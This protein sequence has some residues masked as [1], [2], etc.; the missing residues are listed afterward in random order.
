[1]NK[2]TFLVTLLL[3]L[4]IFSQDHLLDNVYI[5]N[6]SKELK[7]YT[8]LDA[9][10]N[11]KFDEK[12]A[13]FFKDKFLIISSRKV[14]AFS[15][16]DEITNQ[17]YSKVYCL[18]IK[19]SGD[20]KRPLLFSTSLNAKNAHIGAIIF[21][22]DE[23]TAYFTKSNSKNNYQLY[24][25]TINAKKPG[26]WKNIEL[27]NFSLNQPYLDIKDLYINPEGSLLYFCSN[28]QKEGFG[29]YD[30]YVADIKNDKTIGEPL[31]LGKKVNTE[32]DERSPYITGD[33][34]YLFFASSGHH[35]T[36]GLDLYK[37]RIVHHQFT[38]PINLGLDINSAQ[39][40]YAFVMANNKIA[41]FTS[42][43]LNGHG[44]TDIYKIILNPPSQD[45]SG[46]VLDDETNI[47]LP[48]AKITLLD[49]EGN[50]LSTTKSNKNGYYTFNK[51]NSLD[52]YFIHVEKEGYFTLNSPFKAYQI[53]NYTYKE[54]LYLHTEEPEI[55]TLDYKTFIKLDKIYF[56]Y[57]KS[58]VKPESYYLL[59]KVAGILRKHPEYHLEIRSHSDNRGTSVYNL[60]LSQ[61][62]ANAALNYLANKGIS[63]NRL[64]AI[65]FGESNLLIKCDTNC[66]EEQHQTNRRTEFI[67]TNK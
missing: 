49:E 41:Y 18:D 50:I 3:P 26:K 14:G 24:K 29:G 39:D 37:S 21:T 30:I 38:Q 63:K 10:I 22:P 33:K 9:G 47:I 56:E 60:K 58:T 59:D 4:L 23:K 48:D 13:T 43:R 25:A 11:T 32:G 62:R 16:K 51:L 2:T 35:S 44:G 36:G 19:Q 53:K 67:L 64:T 55:I 45:L 66:T 20:L 17:P 61:K 12:G 7:T 8:V 15:K 54:N 6:L 40:D 42:N 46:Y 57:N 1:M 27:L 52:R 28:S 34:K 65:G 31:N 5:N